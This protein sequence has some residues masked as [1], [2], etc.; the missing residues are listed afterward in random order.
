[1]ALATDIILHYSVSII[2]TPACGSLGQLARWLQ[3][4]N[5]TD[6]IVDPLKN[7]QISSH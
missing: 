3:D 7:E 4:P 5:L 1:M 2:H 6:H